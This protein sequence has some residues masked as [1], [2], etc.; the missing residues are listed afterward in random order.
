MTAVADSAKWLRRYLPA[1]EAGTRLVCFPHAGGVARFYRGMAT[2]LAPAAEVL[3]VQYPGRQDRF[4]EP[5]I[6]DVRGMAERIAD[7]LVAELDEPPAL[8]GH[9]MG[10]S[11]AFETARL[12]EKR[13]LGVVA[14][15]VS[16]RRAPR[17]PLSGRSF[18]NDEDLI[19]AAKALGG[20]DPE[21]L[22]HPEILQLVLP[23]LRNDWHAAMTYVYQEGPDLSCPVV[24]LTGDADPHV[25]VGLLDRWG[26][27]TTGPFTRHVYPGDHFYLTAHEATV[28]GVV[29]STLG[30]LAR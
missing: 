26:E 12:L 2:A 27:H 8:F 30:S 1:P 5:L 9:S 21:V 11:V 19:A 29:T 16:G 25:D 15:F 4:A 22:D 13:G 14:L 18:D 6:P 28:C 3:A 17:L 7:V 24:A 10:A 20:P 23:A